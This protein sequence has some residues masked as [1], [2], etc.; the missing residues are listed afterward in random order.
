MKVI[1]GKEEIADAIECYLARQGLNTSSFVLE[2]RIAVSRS[3][4]DNK[5]EVEM[6]K[7]EEVL[8][9]SVKEEP[10]LF[11]HDKVEPAKA[12]FGS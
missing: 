7:K 3:A 9:D 5:I 1:L 2:V 11:N 4:E 10:N 6:K 8:E 12:P